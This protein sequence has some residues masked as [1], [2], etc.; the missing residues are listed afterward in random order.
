MVGPATGKAR[1][2]T[3]DSFTDGTSRQLVILKENKYI[4]KV[5]GTRLSYLSAL[6]PA[7]HSTNRVTA[8]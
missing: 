5:Q 1:Q 3:V 4:G 6:T 8:D 7:M 2:P